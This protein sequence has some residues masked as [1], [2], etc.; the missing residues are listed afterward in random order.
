[1]LAFVLLAAF[2]WGVAIAAFMQ[3]TRLGHFLSLRL[4]WFM[5]AL[6]CGG[7]LL[8]AL[9]LLDDAGRVAWWE[10]VAIFFVSSAGPS[11]RGIV[12]HQDAFREIMDGAKDT[13][14]E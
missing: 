7:V 4:T 12:R 6:G 3:F 13:D 10:F 2:V 11:L 5:T 1:M 8:L 14:S 9:L